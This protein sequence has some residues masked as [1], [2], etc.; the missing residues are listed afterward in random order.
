MIFKSQYS[1][2]LWLLILIVALHGLLSGCA[3]QHTYPNHQSEFSALGDTDA[4][5]SYNTAFPI[6]SAQ[7]GIL[8]GDSAL[9]KGDLDR[10]LFEYIRALDEGGPDSATLYKIGRV[11]LARN[12]KERAGLAL[13]L[14]LKEKSDHV[15]ALVEMGKL[16]IRERRYEAAKELLTKALKIEPN[17][18][19]IYNALG[20]IEDM[21]KNHDQAQKNYIQANYINGDNLI[22][23]NNLGYSYYLM[24]CQ[25]RAEQM[26]LDILKIDPTYMLAWRNL[27][28]VYAKT[29]R[30]RQAVDA[31]SK[32]LS[33]HQ[34]YNDVGYVAMVSGRYDVAQHYFNEAVRLSPS[35]YEVAERNAKHLATLRQRRGFY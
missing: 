17:T 18:P 32:T 15:G 33:E 19:E 1:M 6:A 22:Y 24:G 35:Y 30:Y 34:A 12:D 7:E 16:Q 5:L 27:G 23:L 11:H 20:V 28:L 10:A 25:Q 26:F 8:R 31:L 9:A 14:C 3:S 2:N 21:Q 4:H 13:I 29:A